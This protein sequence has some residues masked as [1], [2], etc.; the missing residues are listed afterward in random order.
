MH[1]FE[2]HPET[3]RRLQQNVELNQRGN[4][5]LHNLAL[6]SAEGSVFFT[7]GSQD[8]LNHVVTEA[9]QPAGTIVVP[10]RRTDALCQEFGIRPEV[11]KID[12]EG[13]EYD[14]LEGFGEELSSVELLIVEMNEK[15]D[16]R[17][18]GERDVHALLTA[19]GLS[20]PWDCDLY[21][22]RFV[23]FT[24]RSREDPIYIS[25]AFRARAPGLGLTFPDA[26]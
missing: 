13:F 2:P 14:V 8:T 24:T 5:T 1:A 7:D 9:S 23:P 3:F 25:D 11:V 16:E 21:R 15:A 19:A 10:S 26:S 20:G 18:H 6:G 17:S 4:V 22:G 12:V